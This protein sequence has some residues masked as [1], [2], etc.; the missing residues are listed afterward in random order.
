LWKN[1]NIIWLY[2]IFYKI[3]FYPLIWLYQV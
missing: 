1:I 2:D 3:L